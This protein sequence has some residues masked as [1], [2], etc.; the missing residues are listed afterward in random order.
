MKIKVY[1]EFSK[2]IL[3]LWKTLEN[4]GHSN[5]FQKCNWVQNWYKTVGEPIH[6]VQLFIVSI[7]YENKV[8]AILPLG[9]LKKSG[10]K[11]LQWLGGIHSD[12]MGPIIGSSSDI[13]LTNFETIWNETL[14]SLPG[15]DLLYLDKQIPNIGSHVN[16]FFHLKDSKKITNAH[17]A[18]F[19]NSWEHYKDG[20]SKK[21]LA[22]TARQRKRLSKLGNL[23]F[24]V[25]SNEEE[26]NLFLEKLFLFKRMRYKEMGVEDV[27]NKK[28]HRDFYLNMP[29]QISQS[30]KVHCSALK[31]N[32]E[33]IA[34]HWGAVDEKTFYYL[35]PAFC[36]GKWSK[37]SPGKILLE[38]LMLSCHHSDLKVFDFTSGDESYKK[39]WAKD[40]FPMHL[41]LRSYSLK[42]SAYIKFLNLKQWSGQFDLLKRV[43]KKLFY[44]VK[45]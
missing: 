43:L 39:I 14:S 30:A 29:S 2:E 36:G 42:G 24:V 32:E 6:K 18:R 7:S 23:N 31:L 28:E 9:I 5:V 15:F 21:V 12:Y 25:V 27:L 33:I 16:P 3:Q 34:I 1:N 4:N 38:D 17:Q 40:S 11:K 10:I 37:Y 8:E 26:N 45:V 35:M 41:T 19:M 22:D 44:K 20:I 13:F